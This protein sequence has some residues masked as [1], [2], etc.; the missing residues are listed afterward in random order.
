M[1]KPIR[2][3]Q[4]GLLAG[5]GGIESFIMDCYRNIDR[6]QVQFDFL[7]LHNER[8]LA[9]EDEILDLGGHVYRVMYSERESLIQ[10]RKEL[11]KFYRQHE[12]IVGVHVHANF[13]YAMP[14]H[15]AKEAGIDLRILHSHN[16]GAAHMHDNSNPVQRAMRVMRSISVRHQIDNDP[17]HYFACSD[18]AAQY[19]FPDKPFRWVKNGINVQRFAFSAV[20]R[21]RVRDTLGISDNTTVV[22]FCGR[23]RTQKNPLFLLQIFS[24]YVSIHADSILLLVGTGEFR[25]QMEDSAR[26]LGI[27]RK[28]CFLGER[29]DVH[30]LYQA[31][32]LFVL[33]SLYEGLP[34]VCIEAQCSGL[35]CLVSRQAV[36]EQARITDLMSYGSLQDSSEVWANTLYRMTVQQRQSDRSQYAQQVR[37]A[38]FEM[39]DVAAGL[40]Q[41][42][43]DNSV[44]SLR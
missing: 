14:L 37:R 10:S 22:G 30:E 38:G 18:V 35:P 34:V 27:A 3:A 40:Q 6:T 32:D 13:P 42:Y 1:E 31:M 7:E 21:K 19:M 39:Q 8:K 4:W 20:K 41:F 44:K 25:S 16:S 29:S 23:F 15:L 36:T 43:I 2:I 12:D 11:L 5:R 33:P 9:Y 17:S 24:D 28:I 26:R